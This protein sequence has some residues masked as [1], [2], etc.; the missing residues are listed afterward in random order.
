MS[1]PRETPAG[2]LHP[3]SPTAFEERYR[4]DPDPWDFAG[5]PAEQARYDD[6]LDVLG[7]GPFA[8]AYEPGCSIGVLTGRLA[9]RC[10]RLRAVDVSPTA[11]AQARERCGDR[12]GL[13]LAV[14]SVADDRTGDHD[15]VVA[16]EVGYYFAGDELAAVVDRLV[17]AL[18]PGGTLLAC[19]WT[20]HSEDHAVHGA[21]V[22]AALGRHPALDP[23]AHRDGPTYLIDRWRRR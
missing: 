1:P 10:D 8:S 14:A 6:L 15:L 19:H 23:T 22:H 16:S 5:S 20:G 12:P 2:V 13:T 18:L 3:C 7:P 21:E 9:H 11:I 4:A 17:G